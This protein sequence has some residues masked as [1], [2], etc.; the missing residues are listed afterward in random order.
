MQLLLPTFSWETTRELS[1][2]L[3]SG[4]VHWVVLAIFLMIPGCRRQGGFA[5]ERVVQ[6]WC[7]I[8][9]VHLVGSI[10]LGFGSIQQ[11]L[12]ELNVSQGS[13]VWGGFCLGQVHLLHVEYS[14]LHDSVTSSLTHK[15]D[16]R[17]KA[18]T[19]SRNFRIFFFI[20]CT[21]VLLVRCGRT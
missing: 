1:P 11:G 15:G 6:S 7:T 19:Q 12:G 8:A 2:R 14:L 13:T 9:V 18:K 4:F 21:E 5:G 10:S 16:P 17:A 3:E 20:V